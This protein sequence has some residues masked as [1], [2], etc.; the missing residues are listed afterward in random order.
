MQKKIR[1]MIIRKE[2]ES[3]YS[4]IYDLVKTAFKTAK[5]SDGNE[6]EFV[7]KLRS[8][9]NYIPE[10]AL[11]V[12]ADEKLIGHIMLTKFCITDGEKKYDTLLLGPVCVALEFRGTGV[13]SHLIRE[14][15]RQAR[16]LGYT[17]VV[18]AGDPE[19]YSRFGFRESTAWNIKNSNGFPDK[20]IMACELIPGALNGVS[21]FIDML[22]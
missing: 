11:V 22:S 6:Q 14:S 1:H 17:S 21:G 8:G 19:Y 5:V 4:Q 10:L 9:G 12:E 2:K 13:G 3:D 18:L 7:N 15:F 16:E 20:Y